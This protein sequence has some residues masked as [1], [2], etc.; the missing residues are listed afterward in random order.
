LLKLERP[1]L[2]GRVDTVETVSG[3]GSLSDEGWCPT[4]GPRS[5]DIDDDA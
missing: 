5:R 4:V 3:D 1:L 2:A